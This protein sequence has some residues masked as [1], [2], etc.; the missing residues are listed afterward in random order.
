MKTI[1]KKMTQ[2]MLIM[3]IN[4]RFRNNNGDLSSSNKKIRRVWTLGQMK[5]TNID[6]MMKATQ[7]PSQIMTI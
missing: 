2:L 1:S 5:D 7:T 4:Q 6:Q 3:A